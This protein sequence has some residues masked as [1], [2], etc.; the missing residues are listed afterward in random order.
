MNSDFTKKTIS[1]CVK[2]KTTQKYLWHFSLNLSLVKEGKI[3]IFPM[4]PDQTLTDISSNQKTFKKMI[5]ST[6]TG[7]RQNTQL[8]LI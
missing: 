4:C 1:F 5:K 2:T 7:L 8:F 3:W 6:K